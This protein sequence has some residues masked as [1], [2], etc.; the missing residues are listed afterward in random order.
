MRQKLPYFLVPGESGQS[1]I[2]TAFTL[3]L[4]LLLLAAAVDFGR[5]FYMNIEIKGAARAGATYGTTKPSDT[6]GMKAAAKAAAGDIGSDTGFSTS[7]SWGCECYSSST[8]TIPGPN[9]CAAPPCGA[10]V[11][12]YVSVTAS[13]T[14]SPILPWPGIPSSLSMS[15]TATM[16]AG[17]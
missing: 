13:D 7:A 11:V 4:L 17:L 9:S 15:S 3:S 16:R 10:N 8:P 2:E 12:Y 6:T 5:A 14:Y 1:L